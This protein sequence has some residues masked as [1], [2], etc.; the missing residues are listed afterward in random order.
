LTSFFKVYIL[1]LTLEKK[2]CL[3]RYSIIITFFKIKQ[4]KILQEDVYEE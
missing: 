3:N 4:S 1:I 2:K